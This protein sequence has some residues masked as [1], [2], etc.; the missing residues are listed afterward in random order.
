MKLMGGR[1]S[2]WTMMVHVKAPPN[3]TLSKAAQWQQVDAGQRR[4]GTIMKDSAMIGG[5]I[6][7]QHN[8]GCLQVQGSRQCQQRCKCRGCSHLDARSSV[9]KSLYMHPSASNSISREDDIAR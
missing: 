4:N 6:L 9:G 1:L 5:C 7:V 3:G 2:L 8:Q